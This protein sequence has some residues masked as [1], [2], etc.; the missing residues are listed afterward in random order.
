MYAIIWTESAQIFPATSIKPY[1]KSG[2]V[3]K[4]CPA[5]GYGIKKKAE[6]QNRGERKRED[7]RY[8]IFSDVHGNLE[9]M[10][11][12]REEYAKQHI[13]AFVF[14][15]DIV[16]YGAN[17]KETI[18]L[19]RSLR[20]VCVAGNHDWAAAGKCPARRFNP[21]ARTAIAWT[22]H[23]LSSAE[24]DFLAR[25]PLLWIRPPAS[26][27]HASVTNPAPFPYVL[28]ENDAAAEFDNFE[29]PIGFIAHS[30]RSETYSVDR[31]GRVSRDTRQRIRLHPE[32]RYLVN[33]GSVGQPRD[34]DPRAC[35]CVYDTSAGEVVFF[36]I[37][38]DT[39]AAAEKIY[40]AGL[41]RVLGDRLM[42]GC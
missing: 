24:K 13:D 11:R 6:N 39:A 33:A 26:Y 1:R 4:G 28:D 23:Q 9:A 42:K 21:C 27:A 5:S 19:L 17:P 29:E 34:R 14:L 20:G 36:R 3:I 37:P 12:V 35:M 10:Q 38:Y 7:M 41:P 30:H 8:G 15:G 16:G 2:T 31:Q 22:A 32:C 40:R 25:L 18:A